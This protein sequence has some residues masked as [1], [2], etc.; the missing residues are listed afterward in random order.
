MWRR[1]CPVTN[2]WGN[3]LQRIRSS[4]ASPGEAGAFTHRGAVTWR[5][6]R[7]PELVRAMAGRPRHEALRGHV[8]ELLR[9]GFGVPH[10][11]IGHEVYLLEG[12][13]RIDTL[14]GDTVIE[15]KGDLRRELGD[16]LTRMPDYLR[17][18][19][20]RTRTAATGLATDGATFIAYELR[21]GTL[22]ELA[23]YATDADKPDGLMAWLEPLMSDRAGLAPEP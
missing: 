18:A 8:T 19:T 17:D 7:L 9:S 21:D 13:G 5:K 4:R 14:W 16:V 6:E 23:R 1:M 10:G 22:V 2:L 11:E 20:G 3:E 12:R 15:L